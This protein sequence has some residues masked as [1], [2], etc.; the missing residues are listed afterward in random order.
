MEALLRILLMLG[1]KVILTLRWCRIR[2]G[3]EH[4]HPEINRGCSHKVLYSHVK[5]LGDSRLEL[6]GSFTDGHKKPVSCSFL[7][8]PPLKKIQNG[9]WIP[10]TVPT[11]C[12]AGTGI[13]ET[14]QKA[15]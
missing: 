11:L 12:V 1:S 10:I 4:P 15:V 6:Y 5:S 9:G 2:F 8:H 14:S 3:Y 13:K 7:L